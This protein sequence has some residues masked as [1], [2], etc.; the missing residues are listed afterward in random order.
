MARKLSQEHIDAYLNG[1]FKNLFR[2]IKEDPELSLEIRRNNEAMVYYRKGKILTTGI[3]RNKFFIRILDKKYYKDKNAPTTNIEDLDKIRPIKSIKQYFKEAKKLV[4]EYKIGREFETQQNITLGN[5]SF[6]NRYL[7]VDMEWQFSQAGINSEEQITKTRIDLIMVD[8]KPNAEGL[9]DIYLAELKVGIGAKD[10]K[11]GIL[12]HINKTYEIINNDRACN[13]LIE[14]VKN[15][16]NQKEELGL[17]GGKHKDFNFALRPKMMFILAY[18]NEIER[19]VFETEFE[20]V[21]C[22]AN[23]LNMAEPMLILHN[24]MIELK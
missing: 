21:K 2:A 9:N 16:I 18:R 10:G 11:S 19:Q 22:R 5:S 20:K 14:D 8:T 17:I 12:D 7:V 1:I 15:I 6:N 23:E 13:D 24:M 4:Y 3:K